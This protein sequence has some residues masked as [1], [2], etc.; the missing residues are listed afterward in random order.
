MNRTTLLT[1]GVVLTLL[2]LSDAWYLAQAALDGA[3]LSCSLG[4]GLD[5]CNIVAQS[6]YSHLF[7]VPLALYGVFF[8]AVLFVTLSILFVKSSCALYRVATALGAIGLIVSTYFLFLQIFII[9]ALCIYCIASFVIA[10]LLAVV[11]WKLAK[12][13][14]DPITHTL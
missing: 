10:A 14:H 8:Y 4:A 2:G 9:K 11:T 3:A 12:G 5:G 1:V 7:G 6:P 13:S